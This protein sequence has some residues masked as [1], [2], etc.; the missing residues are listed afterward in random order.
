MGFGGTRET[1]DISLLIDDVHVASSTQ[2]MMQMMMMM[3][4]MLTM[5]M[6][7]KMLMLRPRRTDYTIVGNGGADGCGAAMM[8]AAAPPRHQHHQLLED[9][10]VAVGAGA[11]SIDDRVLR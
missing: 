4:M 8:I 5:P 7:V 3:L 9:R 2:M 1:L 10:L 6:G 11:G